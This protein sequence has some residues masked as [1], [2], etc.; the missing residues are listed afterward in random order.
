MV[1]KLIDGYCQFIS[2][3]IAAALALMVVL[4][5]GNVFM[6][7]AFNSGFSVSEELS[8]WLFVWLTFLGAV[9]AVRDNAHLGTDMLVGKLGPQGKKICM[10]LSLVLMLFCLWLLFKGS[11]DQSIINWDT[12]SAVMEVS[13]S[14]FYACGMVFSVLSTPILLGD[15]WRLLSGQIDDAHLVLIQESEE[16]PHAEAP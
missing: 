11:Y 6:R 10:G 14:Y 2:Y 7:Y 12:T 1:K 5:F 3:L 16:S 15:L 9:V 13:M 8:R 4:V